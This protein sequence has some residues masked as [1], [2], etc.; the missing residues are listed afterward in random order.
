MLSPYFKPVCEIEPNQKRLGKILPTNPLGT[1]PS[2]NYLQKARAPR[3][4][5]G[6][7][8]FLGKIKIGTKPPRESIL[9]AYTYHKR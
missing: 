5:R 2:V 7:V 8:H 6:H 3:R 4:A 9:L 1:Q